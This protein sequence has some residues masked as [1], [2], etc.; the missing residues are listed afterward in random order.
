MTDTNAREL[1]VLFADIS[2]ST[3]IYEQL[4]DAAAVELIQ[5]LLARM[6]EEAYFHRGAV[7]KSI[8]DELLC[9]FPDVVSA[10]AAATAMQQQA[11]AVA[12]PSGKSLALR[13]GMQF[14]A[15]LEDRGD[16]FG[17]AV[18]VAA[19]VVEMAR[20]GQIL[21]TDSCFEKIP[22]LGRSRIRTIDRLSVRGRSSETTIM[23]V[24][25]QRGRAVTTIVPPVPRSQED[26]GCVALIY[27]GRTYTIAQ[28]GNPFLIGRDASCQLVVASTMASRQHASIEWR[29]GKFVLADRSTNGTFVLPEGGR[30]IHLRREEFVLQGVGVMSFGEMPR[31]E[32]A[33][34]VHYQFRSSLAKP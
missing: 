34:T 32:S 19:R 25:W 33:G 18:N 4:G 29:R 30:A 5:G 6:E 22:L 26:E 13:V 24:M 8:G 14:G 28:Q 31:A 11:A 23:E 27:A 21:I 3:A 1:L 9:T 16:V 15:A 12:G 10:L 7:I 2:G 20:P 17:D